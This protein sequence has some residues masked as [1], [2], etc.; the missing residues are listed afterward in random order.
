MN[1]KSYL[2][3]EHI[4]SSAPEHFTSNNIANEAATNLKVKQGKRHSFKMTVDNLRD[5]L[6]AEEED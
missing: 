6:I 3:T 2:G 1:L 4:T 5:Q